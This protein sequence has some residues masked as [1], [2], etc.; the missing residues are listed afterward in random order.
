[1]CVCLNACVFV[2]VCVAVAVG[3]GCRVGLLMPR[4]VWMVT[5]LLAITLLPGCFVL[6]D[7]SHPRS[8]LSFIAADASLG[9]LLTTPTIL[10]SGSLPELPPGCVVVAA[11]HVVRS[12][13]QALV[14]KEPR[15]ASLDDLAYLCYTSGSTGS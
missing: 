8:R 3:V 9:A 10:A 13:P 4:S 15:L 14:A 11:E 6:L 7:P 12:P 1:M 2:H 5:S